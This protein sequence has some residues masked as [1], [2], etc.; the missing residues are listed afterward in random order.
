MCEGIRTVVENQVPAFFIIQTNAD[1]SN[2]ASHMQGTRHVDAAVPRSYSA[3]SV[4]VLRPLLHLG[5]LQ[6]SLRAGLAAAGNGGVRSHHR[7]GLDCALG[8][9]G[10]FGSRLVDRRSAGP[11][12]WREDPVSPASLVCLQRASDRRFGADGSI[13]VGLGKPFAGPNGR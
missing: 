5:V 10:R 8:F 4:L 12:L 1:A 3:I 2:E 7:A 9:H 13:T 6:H 11:A